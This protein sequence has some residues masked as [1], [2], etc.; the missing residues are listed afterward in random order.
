MN[1]TPAFEEIGQTVPLEAPWK[2]RAFAALRLCFVALAIYVCVLQLLQ[3]GFWSTTMDK[4]FILLGMWSGLGLYSDGLEVVW[5]RLGVLGRIAA[6]VFC[7]VFM[8]G[9]LAT[10]GNP[11]WFGGAMVCTLAVLGS[12]AYGLVQI[13]SKPMRAQRFRQMKR[14]LRTLSAGQRRN[15]RER[16]DKNFRTLVAEGFD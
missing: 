9:E 6:I 3:I 14:Y 12:M 16:L 7:L 8:A 5:R 1:T 4:A 13:M 2:L 10:Q 11:I 15:I